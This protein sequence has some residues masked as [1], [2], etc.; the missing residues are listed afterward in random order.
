M[1]ATFLADLHLARSGTVGRMSWMSMKAI[2]KSNRMQVAQEPTPSMQT[3]LLSGQ[4]LVPPKFLGKCRIIM[5]LFESA[6]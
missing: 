1:L 5:F 3:A 6:A 2:F 4:N